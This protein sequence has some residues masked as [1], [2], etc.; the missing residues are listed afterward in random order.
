MENDSIFEVIGSARETLSEMNLKPEG[1]CSIC[2]NKFGD[3]KKLHKVRFQIA[4]YI[5]DAV[6]LEGSFCT[7]FDRLKL[8]GP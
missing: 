2:L 6:F 4:K 5:Y 3:I 1:E 7:K 8:W